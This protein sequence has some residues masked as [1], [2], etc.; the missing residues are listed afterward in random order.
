MDF[1]QPSSFGDDEVE[2]ERDQSS[3]EGV[4][5]EEAPSDSLSGASEVGCESSGKVSDAKISDGGCADQLDV[6][7]FT[8]LIDL[9]FTSERI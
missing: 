6:S 1:I 3:D 2:R 4:S 7:F 9:R 8:V 5:S